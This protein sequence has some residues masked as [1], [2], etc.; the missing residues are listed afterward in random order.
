VRI[1]LQRAY[2]R[3]PQ[4]RAAERWEA[5]FAI[6]AI[7]AGALWTFPSAVFLPGAEPLLQMAVI[8]VV[9]GSIIGA[10]GVYA[11]SPL[12][13]YSF[14]ALPLLAIIV[15]L[16]LQQGRTYPLLAL[17]VAVFGGVMV[18]IDLN[19]HR[20]V[21]ET[22]RARIENEELV[23][24]LASSEAQLRSAVDEALGKVTELQRAQ[25]AYSQLATQEKLVFDTLPVGVVFFSKRIIVRCNRRLEQMLGYAAGELMGQSSRVLYAS[26][27]LWNQAG[28]GY[29]RLAGGQ[30][31]EGEFRLRCKDG[32]DLWCHSVGRALDPASP[33]ASTIVT[34]ADT[35]ERHAAERALRRGGPC[36]ATWSRPRTTSSGRWTPRGAGPTSARRRC[37]RRLR[38]RRH[39]RSRVPR[40]HRTRGGRARPGGVPAHSGRRIDVRL[41]DAPPAPRRQPRRPVVQRRADARRAWHGGGRDRHRAR[42]YRR[43][44]R[45]RR[46][47]KNVGA[48]A[49]GTRVSSRTGMGAAPTALKAGP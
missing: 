37:A 29:K 48:A 14:S 41:P 19:L 21:M 3:N 40:H 2:E 35:S 16:L 23:A 44:D 25:D 30:V 47:Y 43:E 8:F 28:E 17:M 39:G 22:L 15:Q 11:A 7:G 36:T 26:E 9:G 1:G 13:Y 24:R 10:S 32:T 31:L 20:G 4:A 46:T 18:R 42:R 33:E 38:V 45:R 49:P 5:L 34:Y 12:A 6:G 27:A